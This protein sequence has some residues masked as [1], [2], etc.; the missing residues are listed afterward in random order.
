CY[1]VIPLEG[2][3]LL[4]EGGHFLLP[5]NVY[6]HLAPLLDGQHTVD[7]IFNRLQ[8]E[9]PAAEVF[10]ALTLLRSKGL[11]VN[12]TPSMPPEQVAYWDMLDVDWEDAVRHLQETTV[13]LVSFGEIDTAPFQALLASLGVRVGD[14]GAYWVALTD[15]YLHDGLDAFNQEALTSN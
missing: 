5:G 13:Y 15:D 14:N 11:V 7:E 10:Q 6:I 12:A 4:S 8:D 2:V 1:E 9:V 3:I